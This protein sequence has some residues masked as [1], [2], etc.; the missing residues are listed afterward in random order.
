MRAKGPLWNTKKQ[1][2]KMILEFL[3]P[4]YP[5]TQRKRR[6]HEENYFCKILF[7]KTFGNSALKCNQEMC[8]EM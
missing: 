2:E 8:S 4:I 1:K 3:L 7:E 5:K 6:A